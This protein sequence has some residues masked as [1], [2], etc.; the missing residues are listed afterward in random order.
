MHFKPSLAVL[1]LAA[2][3][4]LPSALFAADTTPPTGTIVISKDK[5][6]TNTA[7]VTLKLSARDT[8]SGIS[9]MSFSSD[10]INWSTPA[11]YST[12]KKWTLSQGDG[13]KTVYAKFSDK[14]GN[15]SIAYSDSITLD[16]QGPSITVTS[17]KEGEVIR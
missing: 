4:I 17:P 2:S 1:L 12:S 13:T 11:R 8:G 5:P 10:N 3:L 7:S 15:W 16:T 14:P 9:Q 6:Y